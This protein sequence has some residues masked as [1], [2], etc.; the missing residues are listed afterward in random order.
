M[1]SYKQLSTGKIRRNIRIK[2]LIDVLEM[3][4]FLEGLQKLKCIETTVTLYPNTLLMKKGK[5]MK[6]K[7]SVL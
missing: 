4:A 3:K 6:M 5:E 1:F 7:C 2:M